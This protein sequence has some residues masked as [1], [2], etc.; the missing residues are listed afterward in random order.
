MGAYASDY[1]FYLLDFKISYKV[2]GGKYNGRMKTTKKEVK[3]VR[4][5]FSFKH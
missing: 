1:Y 3:G 4:A 5:T 2:N